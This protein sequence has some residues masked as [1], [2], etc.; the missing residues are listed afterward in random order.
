[1]NLEELGRFLQS[2]IG[3]YAASRR[4]AY[5]AINLDGGGNTT[6]VVGQQ[7]VNR[8]S[9]PTGERAVANALLVVAG[10]PRS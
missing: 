3:E 4:N 7:V 5:Q 1:M 10:E 2:G 8:P 9:D 6:M